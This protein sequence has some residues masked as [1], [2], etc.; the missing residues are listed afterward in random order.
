MFN[1]LGVVEFPHCFS[2]GG[3]NTHSVSLT[4]RRFGG[5][6]LLEWVVRRVTDSQRLDGVI[7]IVANVP[8]YVQIAQLV[9]PDVPIFI[10]REPDPLAGFS[11]ALREFPAEAVVRVSVD[12]PFVDPTLIDRLV[13]VAESHPGCD[14]I[15]YCSRDGRPAIQSRLGVFAEW[16]RARSILQANRETADPRDRQEAARYLY[17]HPEKFSLRLISVPPE[18]DRDDV[19]LT[20]QVDEDWEHAQEIFEALGPE[21][22]D[23]QRIAGLLTQQPALRRRMAKL[24]QSVI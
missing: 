1:T 24:N 7:A 23:W 15:G 6:S 17:S 10:N 3:L 19:R 12:S 2:Q 11:A 14:Y 4:R 22:L 18:L 9:P 21:S 13:T 16:C 8:D 20:I 5:K